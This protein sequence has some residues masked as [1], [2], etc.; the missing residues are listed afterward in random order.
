[1]S[2]RSWEYLPSAEQVA[3]GLGPGIKAD[4]ERLAQRLSD[5]AAVKYIGD[6]PAEEAGS[7]P[8]LDHAEGRLIVW[9]MERRAERIVFIVRVQYWPPGG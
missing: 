6:P 9:F 8:M 4:V 3:G 7:S 5:A 1:M 2:D